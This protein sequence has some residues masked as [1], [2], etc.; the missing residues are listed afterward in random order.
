MEIKKQ[1]R[2]GAVDKQ[3]RQT[4][5]RAVKRAATFAVFGILLATSFTSCKKAPVVEPSMFS[6]DPAA[7]EAQFSK[8]SDINER[9]TFGETLLLRASSNGNEKCVDFL[10]EHDADPNLKDKNGWAPLMWTA[11]EGHEKIGE[12]LLAK[13]AK[14]DARDKDNRTPLMRASS[15][16][17]KEHVRLLL[18]NGADPNAVDNFG[19]NPLKSA[20]IG[21][22]DPDHMEIA[23]MLRAAGAKE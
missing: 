21:F 11:N 18:D 17:H 10:L 13:G 12:H 20:T 6:D 22:T 15:G 2:D 9:N 4:S 8:G 16:G 7:I 5:F 14:V 19:M 23:K 3:L 1:L